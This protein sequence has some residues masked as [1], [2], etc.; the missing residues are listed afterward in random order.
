VG[1]NY[2]QVPANEWKTT[3]QQ[4][5]KEYGVNYPCL[6]G[7]TATRRSIPGF[8]AFPTTLFLDREGVVRL[9]LVSYEPY[10]KLEAA[11]LELL[12]KP[13]DQA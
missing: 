3:I 10:E 13:N 11:V 2:E 8:Q 5:V 6:I 9:V 4:F 1:I 7:D 12:G